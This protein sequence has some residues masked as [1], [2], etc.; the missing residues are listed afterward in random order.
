MAALRSGMLAPT[1]DLFRPRFGTAAR[2]GPSVAPP[3]GCG[4]KGGGAG[5]R[6]RTGIRS[7]ETDF[8]SVAYTNF[9]TPALAA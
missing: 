6:T 5:G 3:F 4:Q 1:R 2:A 9:A 8:E 7:L